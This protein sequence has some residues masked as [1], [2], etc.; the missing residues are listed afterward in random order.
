MGPAANRALRTVIV[1]DEPI[2]RRALRGYL[3]DAGIGVV[4]VVEKGE[5]GVEATLTAAPDVAAGRSRPP[6][7][8]RRR[9]LGRS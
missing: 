1:D 5:S 8:S 7:P 6:G 4:A 9:G 2:A 3:E